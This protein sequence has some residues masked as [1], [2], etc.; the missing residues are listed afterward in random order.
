MDLLGLARYVGAPTA[1]GTIWLHLFL[2]VQFT[3]LHPS[4]VRNTT[5]CKKLLYVRNNTKVASFFFSF[6]MFLQFRCETNVSTDDVVHLV[7]SEVICAASKLRQ[8]K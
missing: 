3:Y 2:E 5:I 1:A 4:L 8:K 7:L 6:C